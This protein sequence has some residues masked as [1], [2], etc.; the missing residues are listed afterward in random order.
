[1]ESKIDQSLDDIIKKNKISKKGV[2]RKL[3]GGRSGGKGSKRTKKVVKNHNGKPQLKFRENENYFSS[4]EES[5][6]LKISNL[7]FGVTA[8]D[9]LEL[10]SDFGTLKSTSL[11]KDKSGQSLGSAN[12]IFEKKNDAIKA[13][14]QLHG[15]PLDGKLMKIQLIQAEIMPQNGQMDKNS[16][17]RNFDNGK[18]KFKDGRVTKTK[19]GST[20]KPVHGT[21][22]EV[23]GTKKEVHGTKKIAKP[24]AEDLD[25]ELD[26]YL[27]KK[28]D[29]EKRIT[30]TEIEQKPSEKKGKKKGGRG[31]KKES[32]PKPTA[33]DL[34]KEMDDYMKARSK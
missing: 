3:S 24:T 32:E 25:K 14:K 10:F 15:V 34:D 8:D 20:K 18:S 6:K 27:G 2:A 16:P 13:M 22:K 29:T 26:D 11:I 19:N 9:L 17:K 5:A 30:K 4:S 21:K 28:E 23:H 7:D 33:E 1:M 31:A 12:V